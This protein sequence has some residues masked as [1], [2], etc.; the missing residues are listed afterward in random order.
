MKTILLRTFNIS[1]ALLMIFSGYSQSNTFRTMTVKISGNCDM[2]RTTI[3]NTANKIKSVT[4][5]WDKETQLAKISYDS[6]KTNPAAILKNIALA[7]YDNEKYLAPDEVFAQLPECCRYNR[8]LRPASLNHPPDAKSDGMHDHQHPTMQHEE[9][10]KASTDTAQ[11]QA[12]F[13]AYFLLK[14]SLVNGEVKT[15]ASNAGNIVAAIDKVEMAKL[16]GE[17]HSIWM[18]VKPALQNNAGK[19]S[20]STDLSK[21]RNAFALLSVDMYA[22]ARI[23][24]RNQPLYYQHCPMFADGKGANWLSKDKDIRNPYYGAMMLTCGSTVETLP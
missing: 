13:N 22:L 16:S 24:L 8:T 2:C 23:S 5:S 11:L 12:L 6:I 9:P 17:Q 3:E 10:A 14:E 21:Q 1:I 15:A 20:K 18:K 19:I 7:G 4:L